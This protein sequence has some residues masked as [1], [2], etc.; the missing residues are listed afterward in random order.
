MSLNPYEILGLNKDCNDK[1]IR[2]AYRMLAK[3]NHPDV[4][5]GDKILKRL[6]NPRIFYW[7]RRNANNSMI[8]ALSMTI[9]NR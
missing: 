4:G 3:T 1:D 9:R 2:S 6:K 8:M 7:T 5:G